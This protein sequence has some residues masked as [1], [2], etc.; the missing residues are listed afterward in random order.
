MSAAVEEEMA[1]YELAVMAR[2]SGM[3]SRYLQRLWARCPD[4]QALWYMEA[5]ELTRLGLPVRLAERL[6]ACHT[7]QADAPAE[8]AERCQQLGV[9]LITWQQAAYPIILKEIFDPPI[10]LYTRGTLIPDARR[11]AMVGSRR[12]SPDGQ[13]V[14]ASLAEEL[15]RAG[16]TVVS[17]GARGVD[18]FSHQG[19]LKAGRTVA[20]LGCGIDV[21][22]PQE[23]RR[24]F[25][26]IIAEGGA[27][28][29]EYGP[30]TQPLPA[31]FPARNR[32]ISGLSE[33]TLVVEA[34]RRSGSL[35]T[36]EMAL[37]EGRNVYAV[38]GSIWS[39]TSAGCH[40][41]IQQGAGLV[42]C[43]ADVLKDFGVEPAPVR[44]RKKPAMSADERKIWQVLSFEH[45]LSVDEIIMSLPDGEMTN[46]PFLLLQMELKGL[47]IENELHAY[48]RAERE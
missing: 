39:D 34:A 45:P 16:L 43:A 40:H 4:M 10:V 44:R 13:G 25:E 23:N 11:I 21:V 48:R 14:A 9:N 12:L 42:T 19:A 20:V 31:F 15:A 3:G 37:S 29:S 18:T 22:Y 17:G 47:V 6:A 7:Q 32:I 1:P 28:V 30:G 33:G 35:I 5:A 38:P 8:L 24:L 46:L 26:Q 2:V 27:V 36:A 41:L